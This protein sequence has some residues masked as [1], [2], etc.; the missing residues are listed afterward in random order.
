MRHAAGH[1]D[2]GVDAAK[3]H[4]DGEEL[5]GLDN[6]LRNEGR[7]SL[8]GQDRAGAGGLALVEIILGV[9]GKTREVDLELLGDQVLCDPLGVGLLPVHAHTES[10]D[11]AKEK[12][13][14]DWG[15]ANPSGIDDKVE[16]LRKGMGDEGGRGGI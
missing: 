12:P 14:I 3:A 1:A 2:E 4:G 8:E 15:Q 16:L 10:L 6:L 11:P 9:G 13:A 7:A 5:R